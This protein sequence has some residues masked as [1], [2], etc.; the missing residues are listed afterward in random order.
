MYIQFVSSIT[1]QHTDLSFTVTERN[2]H[3]KKGKKKIEYCDRSR[4]D[5]KWES[6]YI[7]DD[8]TH[9]DLQKN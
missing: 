1:K 9:L 8:I 5:D 7:A 6:I 4:I 2:H 3:K